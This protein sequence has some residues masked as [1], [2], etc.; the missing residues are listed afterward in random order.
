MEN[1]R[2][3]QQDEP[4]GLAVLEADASLSFSAL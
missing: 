2:K 3:N 1:G 4:V